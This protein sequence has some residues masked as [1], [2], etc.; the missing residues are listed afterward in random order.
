MKKNIYLAKTIVLLVSGKAGV[1]KS[2]FSRAMIT[3]TEPYDFNSVI[4]PFAQKLKEMATLM[5]WDG[6]KDDKGRKFLQDLGK[7]ARA[8]DEDVWARQAYNNVL[9]QYEGVI[10]VDIIISDDWRFPNEYYYLLNNFKR[11]E[12]FKVRI[13]A[14]EREILKGTPE[15][16][17][18][19]EN[20]L[21]S[22]LDSSYYDFIIDNSGTIDELHLSA[23][24][25]LR[26]ILNRVI[27]YK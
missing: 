2:T 19:S 9:P 4:I 25:T 8:Y 15:Y 17:D 24:R 23:E 22:E 27:I 11:F 10:P 18:I 16:D 1:G 7:V 21:P 13:S 12:I 3:A 14:P 26:Q 20:S 5:G 6:K